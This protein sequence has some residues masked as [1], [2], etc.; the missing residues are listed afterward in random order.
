[1][2]QHN[3]KAGDKVRII[4]NE[5][6]YMSGSFHIFDIGDVVTVEHVCPDGDLFCVRDRDR[7]RN[8]VYIEHVE[9]V[10]AAEADKPAFTRDDI[11]AGYLLEVKKQGKKD[12][13]YMT[14][15]PA[16]YPEPEDLGCCCPGR[17]WWPLCLFDRDTLRRTDGHEILRV[18]GCAS[19][20]LL[21]DNT[22][23]ERELLWERQEE[24]KEEPKA[25]EMTVAEISEK[26]GYEVKI[27]KEKTN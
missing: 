8:R 20:R 17:H 1:M 9:P 25:V 26:L 7:K 14:V 19:N 18:Y 22:P 27:V 24:P 5:C 4:G 10:K 15:A 16:V 11:K 2:K 6:R 3:Y 13:F 23:K 21:L 12:T